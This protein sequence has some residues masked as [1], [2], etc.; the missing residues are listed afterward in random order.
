MAS[1]V[2]VEEIFT[3]IMTGTMSHVSQ[4]HGELAMQHLFFELYD[5]MFSFLE[6]EFGFPA[7]KAFWESIA[8][9]Q[10][11]TLEELMRTKGFQGMEEYWR[12]TLGQEGADYEMDVADDSFQVIVK[13]CPPKE[14]FKARQLEHYPRYCEHCDT[15]YRR[16][17]ERCGYAMEYLPPDAK[18]GTCCGLRITR[19]A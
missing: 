4:Q 5:Y 18:A 17:A 6:R 7:V 9:Q 3:G 19:S 14:W 10:L 8:D 13:R 12:N 16:V 15:L 2:N 1:K 11:A